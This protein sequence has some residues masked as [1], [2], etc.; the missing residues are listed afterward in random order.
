MQGQSPQPGFAVGP[1]PDVRF[2]L[3]SLAQQQAWGQLLRTS[4]PILASECG[5]AWLDLTATNAMAGTLD[6]DAYI[7]SRAGLPLEDHRL[8]FVQPPDELR[9]ATDVSAPVYRPGEEARIGFRVTNSSK[10]S[11]GRPE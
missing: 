10:G 9:I 11:V 8:V 6:L 1:T 2:A 5:R 4:L 7:F 3:R